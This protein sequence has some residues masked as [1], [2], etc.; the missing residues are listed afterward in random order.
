VRVQILPV[1]GATYY[2]VAP[3][4]LSIPSKQSVVLDSEIT[5]SAPASGSDKLF[6]WSLPSGATVDYVIN[7]VERD[8]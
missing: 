5:L 7:G 4:N 3:V 8:Q 6:A 2:D 1:G